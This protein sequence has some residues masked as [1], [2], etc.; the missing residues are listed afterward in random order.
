ML[1]TSDEGW[2]DVRQE[3]VDRQKLVEEFSRCFDGYRGFG[4][5]RQ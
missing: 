5:L 3:F 2:R 1:Q 4:S